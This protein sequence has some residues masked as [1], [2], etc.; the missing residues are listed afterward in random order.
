MGYAAAVE[1]G[2]AARAAYN[3]KAGGQQKGSGGSQ[4][5]TGPGVKTAA[6]SAVIPGDVMAGSGL[7]INGDVYVT[8]SQ[9]SN[10]EQLLVEITKA[11]QKKKGQNT[12][13]PFTP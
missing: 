9:A 5:S 11:A 13:N 3:S 8:S 7:T 12:G 2:E 1:A 4:K 6:G 10:V